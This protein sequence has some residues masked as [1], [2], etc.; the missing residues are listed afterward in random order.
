MLFV[1]LVFAG[2]SIFN[3]HTQRGHE[4]ERDKVHDK[5]HDR[6]IQIPSWSVMV[7]KG[8]TDPCCKKNPKL[9]S[10]PDMVFHPGIRRGFLRL[11]D[12]YREYGETT[13]AY[14]V[15]K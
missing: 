11:W 1:L 7:P 3:T 4:K 2:V 9:L 14:M 13:V 15:R 5:V 12:L 6:N 8:Q 10:A